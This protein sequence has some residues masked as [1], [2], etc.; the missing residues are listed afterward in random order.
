MDIHTITLHV[1]KMKLLSPFVSSLETVQNRESVL[2]E[3]KDREGFIG[4][5]EVVAFSSPWY[6][7]ETIKT[8]LHMLEDFLIPKLFAESITHPSEVFGVL[9]NVKRN[10]MAKAGLETAVWDLFAKRQNVSLASLLGGKKMSVDAGVVVG[11]D[12]TKNMLKTIERRLLEGYRRIKIKIAPDE[13]V[14]II[15][16]IKKEFPKIPLM[17]D[18]NSA[19]NLADIDRLKALDEYELMMIEQPLASDDIIDHAKA[20]RVLKTPICL[21]ESIT[22][23]DDARKAIELGSCQIMNVKI[24][25]VGGLYE[26]IRI[27]DICK[28][29]NIPVWCGGMLETGISRAHNIALASLE[30]FS[31]PGDISASS[32]YWERDVIIPEVTVNRG[33]VDVPNN[34]GIGFDINYKF[35]EEITITKKQFLRK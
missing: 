27:H 5:G 8:S 3:I 18:A 13:D 34:P 19:Y 24:G 30:N 21:D 2:I 35:L 22:S 4:W 29:N 1:T 23:Y 26:A 11:L 28:S 20:Q 33:Q 10:R 31:I 25:R 17:V 14:E 9:A 32:R 12:S 16:E 6:T 15:K 7:E